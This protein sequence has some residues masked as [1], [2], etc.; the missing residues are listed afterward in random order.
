LHVVGKLHNNVTDVLNNSPLKKN[1]ILHGYQKKLRS[2]LSAAD[3]FVLPFRMGGG[4]RLKALTAMSAGLPVVS[5]SVGVDGLDVTPNKEYILANA[6][7]KFAQE[8]VKLITNTQKRISLSKNALKYM[9]MNHSLKQN[10]VF[11]TDYEQ[12]TQ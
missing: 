10:A 6:A 12:F 5:T 9:E 2:F 7:E 1:I 11:L 4:V 8:V 3:M